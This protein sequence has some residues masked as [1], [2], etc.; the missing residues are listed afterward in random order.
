MHH[1]HR[2][3]YSEWFRK[4]IKDEGLAADAAR[5]EELTACVRVKVVRV[6]GLLWNGSI[7][8]L[9]NLQSSS[10]VMALRRIRSRKRRMQ[11][12]HL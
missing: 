6:S 5:V 1:L 9:P 11:S 8:C 2:G 10:R 3:D 12:I 7:R 4:V